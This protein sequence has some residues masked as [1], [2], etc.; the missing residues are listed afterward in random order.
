MKDLGVVVKFL[1]MRIT[2]LPQKG[3]EIYQGTMIDES[4]F[5]FGLQDAHSVT[6]PIGL[7]HDN[8]AHEVD[9][10]LPKMTSPEKYR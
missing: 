6:T 10:L 3:Y 2:Y 9:P 5:R 7:D 1:G 4:I 8:D